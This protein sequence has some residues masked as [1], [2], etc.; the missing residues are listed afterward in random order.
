MRNTK[1]YLL[2]WLS[3]I[4]FNSKNLYGQFKSQYPDIPRID[5]HMHVANDS[6][7]IVN[8]LNLRTAM[9]KNHDI[10]MALW[11][12]LGNR[13]KPLPDIE[14]VMRI[15]EGHFMCSIADYTTHTGLKIAPEKLKSYLDQGYAGYKIWAGPWYRRLDKKEDGLPYIDNPAHEPTFTEMERIGM[16]GASIHVAD[17][18]GPY[19]QRTAWLADPIEYWTQIT[20]WRN[21]LEKHPDLVTV[22]AH[23]NWLMCQDAQLDYLRNMLATF[24][25][26]NVDLAATF[27]Y[28]YLVNPENLRSFMI[29]WSDRLLFATDA[30]A[31]ETDEETASSV[32]Q[33]LRAFQI[34]ETNEKVKGGFFG[35]PE[36]QGLNLPKE[37]LEKI[38][39]KN[40]A[41]IYPGMKEQMI[42]LGYTF[43]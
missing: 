28:Y 41:R 33:Y 25:N 32:Q 13:G 24:P 27:Q 22:M 1:P 38:Y 34:L 35:G 23:G 4:L 3:L 18:N 26:L 5:V 10:D 16:P 21:V 2:A 29:E 30:G 43:E 14:K 12:N 37:V 31:W 6:L 8:Y 40:A 36:I 9:S 19:G 15:G 11:L 42:K 17:P 7:G 39:Y 20:S